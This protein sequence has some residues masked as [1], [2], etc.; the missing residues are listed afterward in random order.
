[1]GQGLLPNLGRGGKSQKEVFR[2]L[3]NALESEGWTSIFPV[4]SLTS[5]PGGD[6]K[7][8]VLLMLHA[9]VCCLITGP[10]IIRDRERQLSK[11]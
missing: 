7:A 5:C 10:R 9:R 1:M 11:L 8:L 4:V 3:Q 2:S 6:E